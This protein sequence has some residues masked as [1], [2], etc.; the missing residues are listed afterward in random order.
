V[1]AASQLSQHIFDAAAKRGLHLALI[2]LPLKF[3]PLFA[4]E[5][6]SQQETV[7][8]LRSVLMKPEHREWVSSILTILDAAHHDATGQ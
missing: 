8:C 6:T 3:I 2:R 7:L 4:G 5:S 1:H